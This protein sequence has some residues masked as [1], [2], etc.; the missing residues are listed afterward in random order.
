MHGSEFAELRA[1]VAVAERRNFGRAAQA[2]GMMPS[3]ISQTVKALE[4]RLGVRLLNRTTRQVSLTDAGERLL[5]RARPALTELDAAVGDLDQFRDTPTGT[6]RLNVSSIAARIVLAPA[7]KAFLAAHPGI[8]L[9]VTVDDDQS[10]IVG[11]R[12]DAGIRVGHKVAKDMQALC[13]SAPSRL[14]AVASP[15]YLA[16]HSPP[17]MPRDL[18]RHACIRLRNDNQ[19]LNWR[20]EKGKSKLEIAVSGP[21]IVDSMDLVAHAALDGI[22]IG[23]TIEAHV[24]ELLESGRLCALLQDWSPPVHSY[25]LY[26]SGRG[27]LPLPLETF[28]DFLRQRFAPNPAQR[29]APGFAPPS[30]P[31]EI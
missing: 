9:D 28:I 6:L 29:D 17:A 19:I 12:F 30:L 15:D 13:V 24:A 26:Y 20:F 4:L 27:R 2:L 1:F 16:R 3:T 22:G 11:G 21:L 18:H 25:Y 23:Y 8:T 7:M 10:D 5:A 31:K 14:I